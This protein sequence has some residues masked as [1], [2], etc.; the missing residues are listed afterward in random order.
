MSTLYPNLKTMVKN[1]L[2]VL[3]MFEDGRIRKFHWWVY[4]KHEHVGWAQN[5][6][7]CIAM[8]S[9]MSTLYPNMKTM[10]QNSLDGLNMFEDDSERKFCDNFW[11]SED[12]Y[13]ENWLSANSSDFL[14]RG[15][16]I[17]VCIGPLMK[18]FL[19]ASNIFFWLIKEPNSR[20]SSCFGLW[21]WSYE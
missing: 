15:F 4:W 9:L 17:W 10:V 20:V 19:C 5:E 6:Q 11:S 13:C 21:F 12:S 16:S 1:S 14:N 8:F 2:D 18:I 3:N 7:L